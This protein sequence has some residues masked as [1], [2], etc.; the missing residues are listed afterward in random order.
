M[1]NIW[2]IVPFEGKD[3]SGTYTLEA[4]SIQFVGQISVEPSAAGMF[5]VDYY[6]DK[7]KIRA[8]NR[9]VINKDNITAQM[10][11]MGMPAEMAAAQADSMMM[12]AIQNLLGG[13]SKE[14]RYATLSQ[15]VVAFGME[16][17]PI[18][19]QNGVLEVL[20]QLGPPAVT[21]MQEI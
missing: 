4:L 2:K 19:E 11:G 14:V 17:L 1:A 12:A 13:E 6:T 20:P 16:L 10:I 8:A 15:I 7:K 21:P 3:T 18:E 5:Q 9:D